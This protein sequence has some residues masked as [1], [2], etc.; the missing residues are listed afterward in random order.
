MRSSR[1]RTTPCGFTIWAFGLPGD[2]EKSA[3]VRRLRETLDNPANLCLHGVTD[4]QEAFIRLFSELITD[5]FLSPSL[6]EG[7]IHQIVGTAYRLVQPKALP[8]VSADQARETVK[9]WCTTSSTIWIPT[10]LTSAACRA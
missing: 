5:D 3:F 6:L 10:L 2:A 4:M 8:G 1:R 9:S 7:T